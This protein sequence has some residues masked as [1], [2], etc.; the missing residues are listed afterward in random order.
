MKKSS[1]R[2]STAKAKVSEATRSV[3]RSTPSNARILRSKGMR[4]VAGA[5]VAGVFVS[6][7][8][9]LGYMPIRD[10][11]GQRAVLAQ[12]ESEFETLADANEELQT[13]VNKLQTPEGVRNAARNQLNMVFPGEKRVH[14]LPSPALPTDMPAQWP[15]SMVSGIV[16]VRSNI[17]QAHNAPL[18]PL[19]P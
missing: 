14:L 9:S 4:R 3:R 2:A 7:V 12:K 15:Y 1:T 5:V 16:A 18:A 13:E 19:S 17:A 6:L 10:Y 11:F 8:F